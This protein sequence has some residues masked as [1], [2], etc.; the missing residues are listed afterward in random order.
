M[1]QYQQHQLHKSLWWI[2]ILWLSNTHQATFSL[3]L[4]NR[5]REENMI[6]KLMDQDKYM[7]ITEQLPSKN[8]Y[9]MGN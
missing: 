1:N 3:T 8:R 9:D 2:S 4:L 7:D 5:T 6:E